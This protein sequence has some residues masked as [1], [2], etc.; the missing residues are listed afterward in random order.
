MALAEAGRV[1]GSINAQPLLS[2][3][4]ETG[5]L[6]RWL[7]DLLM[8]DGLSLSE[9]GTHCTI[10]AIPANRSRV[11]SSMPWNTTKMRPGGALALTLILKVTLSPVTTTGSDGSLSFFEKSVG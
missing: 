9:K 10:K 5:V 4:W 2:S 7:L 8:G 1:R 11:A 6:M 3:H